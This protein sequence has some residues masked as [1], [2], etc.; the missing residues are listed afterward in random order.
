[1]SE[2]EQYN[3]M[4]EAARLQGLIHGRESAG[5]NMEPTKKQW[6]NFFN[7]YASGFMDGR[8]QK[9]KSLEYYEKGISQ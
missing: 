3:D 5:T 6:G 4:A 1:M 2:L 8:R 9:I 7:Y